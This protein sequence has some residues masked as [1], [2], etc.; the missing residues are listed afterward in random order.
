VA[1]VVNSGPLT[2]QNVLDKLAAR[3]AAAEAEITDLR[4]QL[5]KLSDALTMAE[6]ERDRWAQARESV[7]ALVAEEHPQQTAASRPVTPA[8]Q[9]ILAAFTEASGPLRAKELCQVLHV[10][11]EPRHIEGM[12]SKLKKL[13][14]R[15]ILTEPSP[16]TFMLTKQKAA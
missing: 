15:G 7:L 16:G 5:A 3:H 13:T 4:D 6:R 1:V 12:R 10:G 2:V 14:A 11:S 9:Q 8:Y